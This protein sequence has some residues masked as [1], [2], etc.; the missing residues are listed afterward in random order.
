MPWEGGGSASR[1]GRS[2]DTE[3][4]MEELFI[5]VCSLW[6]RRAL[7]AICVD[8]PREMKGG[9]PRASCFS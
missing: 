9:C 1:L 4:R 3:H 8:E 2:R 6:D 7:G 5:L